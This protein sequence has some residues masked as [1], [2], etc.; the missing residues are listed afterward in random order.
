MLHHNGL[1]LQYVEG[2]SVAVAAVYLR[3]RQSHRHGPLIELLNQPIRERE[4]ARWQ[5]AF[6]EAPR[7]V[8][9]QI[10]NEAWASALPSMRDREARSRGLQLLPDFWISPAGPR[11]GGKGQ[12]DVIDRCQR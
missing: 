8:L 7:S 11:L 10:S 2:P 9:E 6:A 3:I 5:M 4:F 12:V 1:F